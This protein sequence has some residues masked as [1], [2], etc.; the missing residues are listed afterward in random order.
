MRYELLS[1]ESV[2]LTSLSKNDMAFLFELYGR[3]LADEDYFGMERS[4]CGEGAYPLKGS[5]RVTREIHESLLFR[6]AED[7]VDRV[8]LRQGV[9]APD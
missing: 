8:G 4:V 5:A 1:G 7:V 6:V 2:V 3:A 9:I